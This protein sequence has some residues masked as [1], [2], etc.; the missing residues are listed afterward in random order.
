M[1]RRHLVDAAAQVVDLPALRAIDAADHIQH[2]G[3]AGAVGPDQPADLPR[4][5]R[6]RDAIEGLDAP[7][8]D[9]DRADIEHGFRAGHGWVW[10]ITGPRRVKV[11]RGWP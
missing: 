9:R 2:C 3:L 4:R 10:W 6:Q 5:D 8:G 1:V 11:R 7:E